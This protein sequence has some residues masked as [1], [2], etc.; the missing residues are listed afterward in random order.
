MIQQDQLSQSELESYLNQGSGKQMGRYLRYYCPLH[1][2]DN[3]RSLSVDPDSGRF[4]CYSCQAWGYLD[5]FKDVWREEQRKSNRL[6]DIKSSVYATPVYSRRSSMKRSAHLANHSKPALRSRP[7]PQPKTDWPE[8]KESMGPLIQALPGSWGQRYLEWRGLDLEIAQQ[9]GVG[10]AAMGKWPHISKKGRN[11]RQW[12]WGRVV[13]PH[14]TPDGQ[15]INLYGRAVGSHDRVPKS[16]RHDH[17]PGQKGIFNAEALKHESVYVCEGVFDALSLLKLGLSACAVF[18]LDGLRWEWVKSKQVIFAF[19]QDVAGSKWKQLAKE[20][21]LRGKDIWWLPPE[22]FGG[23]KDINEAFVAGT[24]NIG[25]F[26][27]PEPIMPIEYSEPS[28]EAMA[29]EQL[30]PFEQL[31]ILQE[32]YGF[33]HPMVM[34]YSWELS[35]DLA[36][37][38]DKWNKVWGNPG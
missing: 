27:L 5:E 11:V 20:G 13:F 24:L 36:Q 2:S 38:E 32:K 8:Y 12:K 18:G 15:M 35:E 22:A 31:L 4:K 26:N 28:T 37:N 34:K 6:Q 25:E 1:G 7:V 16:E 30:D 14:T 9:Y 17:L 3:Q 33:D 10:Y 19:D 29:E 23:H 21:L